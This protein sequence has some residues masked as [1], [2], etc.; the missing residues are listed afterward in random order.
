MVLVLSCHDA[1]LLSRRAGGD[2][3]RLNLIGSISRVGQSPGQAQS[4]AFGRHVAVR[5]E[6]RDRFEAWDCQDLNVG[7]GSC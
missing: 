7:I 1:R 2:N 5:A 3:L 4:M 6:T